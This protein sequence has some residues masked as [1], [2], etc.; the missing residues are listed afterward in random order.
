MKCYSNQCLP[1]THFLKFN[2]FPYPYTNYAANR[3]H[4]LSFTINCNLKN[5]GGND[6]SRKILLSEASP[7]PLTIDNDD[8]VNLPASPKNKKAPFGVAK[9]LSKKVLQ[10]LSNLP[11]AIAE[12][13]AIAFL[14][15]LGMFLYSIS[16]S[17]DAK[18]PRVYLV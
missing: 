15:A 5:K 18:S 4:T 13:F 10:I 16:H 7:P 17:V 2:P 8:T 6:L 12:M 1:K 14:M 9:I 3:L 11:L